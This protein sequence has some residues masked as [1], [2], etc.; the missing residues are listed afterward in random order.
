[1]TL[2]TYYTIFGRT[3]L[4][5]IPVEQ[6]SGRGRNYHT[7]SSLHSRC[8]RLA[9][10]RIRGGNRFCS[11]P[12]CVHVPSHCRRGSLFL[13]SV[14]CICVIPTGADALRHHLCIAVDGVGV[15]ELLRDIPDHL[16]RAARVDGCTASQVL[17]YVCLQW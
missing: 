10:L 14:G 2:D 12:H 17:L 5:P 9:K 11:D 16:L 7:R 13:L 1:M 8:I 6:H 15:N 4:W 3:T